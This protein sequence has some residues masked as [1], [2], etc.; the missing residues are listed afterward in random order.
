MRVL[1][2]P[3]RVLAKEKRE[4]DLTSEQDKAIEAIYEVKGDELRVCLSFNASRP[5]DF[6]TEKDDGRALYR[7]RR[8]DK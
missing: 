7:L 8:V 3:Y 4:I 2:K 1:H 5:S 6:R